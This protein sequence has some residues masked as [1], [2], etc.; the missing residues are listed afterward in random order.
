MYLNIIDWDEVWICVKRFKSHCTL[1]VVS[2]ITLH[3]LAKVFVGT[4][5]FINI[6]R[7]LAAD[8]TD[9][10]TLQRETER[11]L[12]L[13]PEVGEHLKLPESKPLEDSV[14]DVVE[15]KKFVFEGVNV[16]EEAE[17][18]REVANF[19]GKKLTLNQLELAASLI[20]KH[21]QMQGWL[22][23]AWVPPQE[24]RDGI[25]RIRVLKGKLGNVHAEGDMDDSDLIL[26][27]RMVA[28]R[29][30][31][32]EQL[33][34]KNLE[35]GLLLANDLP[36]MAVTG[37]LEPGDDVGLIKANVKVDPEPMVTGEMSIANHGSRVVDNSKQYS[38]AVSIAPGGGQ[39]VSLRALV[40]EDLNLILMRYGLPVGVDGMR[41]NFQVSN[42]QYDLHNALEAKGNAQTYLAA[43]SWP[44]LR[45]DATNVY[46]TGGV[47][48]RRYADDVLDSAIKR[49]QLDVFNLGLSGNS[50]DGWA[51]GGQTQAAFQTSFGNLDLQVDSDLAMDKAGP[52]SYG[53]YGKIEANLTRIQRIGFDN[54]FLYAGL[55][56]QWASK[57]LDSSE[58]F[59]LGGPSGVRAYPVSEGTGDSGWILN[60]ELR[61][62]LGAGW[63][64]TAFVDV[65]SVR[66]HV[67]TWGGWNAWSS[68][69]NRYH[70]AGA[71]LGLSWSDVN[72]FIFEAI[73][74]NPIGSNKGR[75][76]DGDNQ[77]GS[78]HR[79]R[80]WLRL[81]KYF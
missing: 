75:L 37:V 65:G 39:Q 74:A 17:L 2:E 57:N 23:S 66:Q 72:G 13:M 36:G 45:S 29:L 47:G 14:G 25:V 12:Q 55:S 15:V 42:L 3:V 16:I 44:W 60:L 58:K 43:M 56:G 34:T 48:H 62:K 71:G 26:A 69:K 52:Q 50:F 77:D 10:G 8:I 80:G 24:I 9:A 78:S 1:S 5:L 76:D 27:G 35:R 38:A 32:G 49:K 51:G 18:E 46:L 53:Q 59:M 70:L 20:S 81:T 6:S 11:Q 67:D 4:V 30:K 31:L 68:V 54:L 40:N 19:L 41:L 61:R 73:V 33:S 63:N 79:A 21:Y 64:G 22:V 7:G 28:A